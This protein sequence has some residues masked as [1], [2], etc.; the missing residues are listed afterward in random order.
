MK[1]R[2]LVASVLLAAAAVTYV[3]LSESPV[4]RLPSDNASILSVDFAALRQGGI[5]DLLSGPVVDEEPEYKSFVAI[6]GFDYRRDLDHAYIAFHP[7]GV[8]FLVRG[9]FDWGRLQSY[10]R[11]QGGECSAGTCRMPGSIPARRISFFPVKSN[12]MAMAVSSGE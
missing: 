10:A 2:L 7:D 8:F 5:L 1:G 3:K 4:Y 11:E 9:R 6:T 12:L